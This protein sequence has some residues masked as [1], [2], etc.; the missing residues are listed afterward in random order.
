MNKELILKY[1]DEFD[2]SLYGGKLQ[3]KFV[4]DPWEEAPKDI[5]SYSANNLI[6]KYCEP[7]I[8]QLPTKFKE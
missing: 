2:H 5:F 4:N 6:W 3:V 7:F 8:G 1:K